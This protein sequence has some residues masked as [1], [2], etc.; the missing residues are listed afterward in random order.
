MPSFDFEVNPDAANPHRSFAPF[1][2]RRSRS[3]G[4]RAFSSP[5]PGGQNLHYV[6]AGL[7]RR[8]V[9][10]EVELRRGPQPLLLAA[11]HLLRP[12]AEALAPPQLHLNKAEELPPLRN[13][14]QLS[15]AAPPAGGYDPIAL[16]P[17]K[18]RRQRLPPAAPEAA[19]L[20]AH[21]FFRKDRRWM[22]L[23][24]YCRNSS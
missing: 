6:E 13:Q 3:V 12:G 19:V 21:R 5:F 2:K 20:P 15:E 1:L 22:G 17:Q 24:P 10:L 4:S 7:E 8:R 16:P 14:V 23:G 9:L 11:V 18:F